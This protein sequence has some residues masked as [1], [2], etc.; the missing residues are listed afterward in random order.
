MVQH[1]EL[2][3]KFAVLY[4]SACISDRTMRA[5]AERMNDNLIRTHLTILSSFCRAHSQRLMSRMQALSSNRVVVP[6]LPEE[7][8]L[9]QDVISELKREAA[10]A[11]MHCVYYVEVAKL[12]RQ[13]AD[14]SSTGVC[15]LNRAEEKDRALEL[16]VMIER[17]N[18]NKVA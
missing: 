9:G 6:A 14:I 3:V 11:S 18:R 13:S 10:N 16:R 2:Y 4:E 1:R 5:L 12:A 7:Y 8:V 15:E 17:L